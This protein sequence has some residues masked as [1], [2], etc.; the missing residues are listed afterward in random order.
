MVDW[1]ANRCKRKESTEIGLLPV[2]FPHCVAQANQ[3]GV[4]LEYFRQPR[5]G[6]LQGRE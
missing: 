3:P 2:G 1:P 5:I 6:C 4:G